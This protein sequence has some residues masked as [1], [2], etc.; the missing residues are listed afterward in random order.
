MLV[1]AFATLLLALP[2]WAQ[3]TNTTAPVPTDGATTTNETDSGG[4]PGWNKTAL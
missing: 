3:D 1:A 4:A 2:T